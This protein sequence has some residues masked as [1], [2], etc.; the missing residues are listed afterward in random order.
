METIGG[1]SA[2]TA[3]L[4]FWFSLVTAI[5]A[6]IEGHRDAPEDIISFAKDIEAVTVEDLR[7][8]RSSLLSL[9][10]LWHGKSVS[11][12]RITSS[13]LIL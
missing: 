12:T 7:L 4:E 6:F 10:L 2:V 8:Q 1:I 11:Y 13:K 3:V 5:H 9:W